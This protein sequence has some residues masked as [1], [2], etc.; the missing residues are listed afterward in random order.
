[1]SR[2]KETKVKF[3]NLSDL[4]RIFKLKQQDLTQREIDKIISHERSNIKK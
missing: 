4:D 2:D 1:M 3:N